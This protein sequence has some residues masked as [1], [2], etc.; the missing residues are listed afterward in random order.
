MA[1]SRL[2]RKNLKSS[3]RGPCGISVAC[4]DSAKEDDPCRLLVRLVSDVLFQ[5]WSM[6]LWS[7]A[8][9]YTITQLINGS[10]AW[11]LIKNNIMGILIPTS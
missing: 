5:S 1:K 7:L 3:F 8:M 9:C 11:G 2:A 4:C 10:D 6:V